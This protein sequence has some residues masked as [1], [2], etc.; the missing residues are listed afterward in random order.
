MYFSFN[1]FSY[2]ID[3]FILIL[4]SSFDSEEGEEIIDEPFRKKLSPSVP[5][6]I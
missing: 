3:N 1:S 4:L 2:L 6:I 5:L